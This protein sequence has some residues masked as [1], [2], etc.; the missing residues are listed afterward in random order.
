MQS[1][2]NLVIYDYYGAVLWQS[3]SAV[4][5]HRAPFKLFMQ[6]DRNIVRKCF[7]PTDCLNKPQQVVYDKDNIPIWATMTNVQM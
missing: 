7:S 5:T 6:N 2:G 4:G 3:G 1:D